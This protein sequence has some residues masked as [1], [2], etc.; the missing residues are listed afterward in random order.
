MSV[1]TQATLASISALCART[2][3]WWSASDSRVINPLACVNTTLLLSGEKEAALAFAVL[4]ISVASGRS[5]RQMYN[6]RTPS[7]TPIIATLWPSGEIEGPPCNP[8]TGSTFGG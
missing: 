4:L 5:S 3:R 1:E 8:E 7:R 6:R 2:A